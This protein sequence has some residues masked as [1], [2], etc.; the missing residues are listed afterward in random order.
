MPSNAEIHKDVK[1]LANHFQ[2]F[3]KKVVVMETEFN[4]YKKKV[5]TEDFA[6]MKSRVGAIMKVMW[7]CLFIILGS[8]LTAGLSLVIAS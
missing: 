7:W 3:A 6:V 5:S 2:D 1:D 4:A 8:V